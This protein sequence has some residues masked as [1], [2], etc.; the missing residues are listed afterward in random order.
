MLKRLIG[1]GV[2]SI[3][4]FA[5][6]IQLI[7]YGRDHT[8][9]AGNVEPQWNGPQTRELAVRA[10]FD[11]HS[12]LTVWPWY[13]NVAPISWIIQHDVVEGRQR[14]NFSAMDRPQRET[15]EIA[16]PVQRGS[17]PPVYYLPLHPSAAL[18]STEKDVLVQGLNATF[19][20]TTSGTSGQFQEGG[21]SRDRG[22]R[23]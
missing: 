3:V 10:C 8:N 17:M 9:P 20:V 11:C 16:R 19:G 22:G 21:E 14:L 5:L 18:S 13:S 1:L 7:P 15:G 12:N 23:D 4:V 6:A 2:L